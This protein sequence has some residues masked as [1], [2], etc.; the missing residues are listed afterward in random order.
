MQ[1]KRITLDLNRI[2]L[3]HQVLRTAIRIDSSKRLNT[4]AGKID[5]NT[6]FAVEELG[7]AVDREALMFRSL[8]LRKP[9]CSG[10]VV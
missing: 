4:K 5:A 8:S 3:D 10:G 2:E 9:H 1:S 6:G 7:W